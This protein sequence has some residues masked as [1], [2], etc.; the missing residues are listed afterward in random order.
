[1]PGETFT[2]EEATTPPPAGGVPSPSTMRIPPEVQAQRDVERRK[3]VQSEYQ[4]PKYDSTTHEALGRELKRIPA[5]P[6][7]KPETFSFEEALGKPAGDPLKALKHKSDLEI[8]LGG[9]GAASMAI[10]TDAASLA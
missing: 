8:T 7:A 9:V 2:F 4:D 5:G 10:A 6:A 1:M 3:I